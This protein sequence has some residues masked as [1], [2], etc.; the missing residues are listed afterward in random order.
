MRLERADPD[1]SAKAAAAASKIPVLNQMYD[2]LGKY[3]ERR[4]SATYEEWISE[5][6]PENAREYLQGSSPFVDPR[7]YLESSDHRRLWL[8]L[9]PGSHLEVEG[10]NSQRACDATAPIVTNGCD[11]ETPSGSFGNS[12]RIGAADVSPAG[13]RRNRAADVASTTGAKVDETAHRVGQTVGGMFTTASTAAKDLFEHVQAHPHPDHHLADALVRVHMV[14]KKL[15]KDVG[16][17]IS[18]HRKPDGGSCSSPSPAPWTAGTL[19][20]QGA[21]QQRLP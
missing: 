2:D 15:V 14:A 3:L 8:M 9:H 12:P 21:R 10:L 18:R 13:A 7:F 20:C 6:H 4:P 16:D 19:P 17:E 11:G 1:A 5:Y